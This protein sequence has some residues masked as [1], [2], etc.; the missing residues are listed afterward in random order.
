MG[1]KP[2]E[3]FTHLVLK[4]SSSLAHVVLQV[5][6]SALQAKGAHACEGSGM[7]G[8]VPL[9]SQVNPGLEAFPLHPG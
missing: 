4:Q 8:H 9:P 5:P 6:L 1:M 2:H 7:T 3:P